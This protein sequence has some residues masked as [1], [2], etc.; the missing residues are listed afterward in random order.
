[1]AQRPLVSK[2]LCYVEAPARSEEEMTG[3]GELHQFCQACR[4]DM[5][6]TPAQCS[7]NPFALHFRRP[8]P[9]RKLPSPATNSFIENKIPK[10]TLEAS[11]LVPTELGEGVE[12]LLEQDSKPNSQV[13]PFT[14]L[15]KCTLLA[16]GQCRGLWFQSTFG[17]G[18][19]GHE[20]IH[21]ARN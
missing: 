14:P 8:S 19:C 17:C 2:Y 21:E 16:A 18:T 20:V 6:A 7:T 1:M 9:C 13:V 4:V 12:S 3:R 11:L 10:L 5:S 15:C